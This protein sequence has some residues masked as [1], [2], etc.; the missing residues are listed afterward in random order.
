MGGR[1]GLRRSDVGVRLRDDDR[2]PVDAGPTVD[3][4]DS[5]DGGRSGVGIDEVLTTT[6]GTV[7]LLVDGA[8]VTYLRPAIE[9]D[10]PGFMIQ[11]GATGPASTPTRPTSRSATRS[12]CG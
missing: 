1:G 6:P 11:E 2:A 7:D 8:L 3:A 4:G 5:V 10:R 9:G 12:A